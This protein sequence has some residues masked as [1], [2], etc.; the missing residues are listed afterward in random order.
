MKQKFSRSNKKES[1]RVSKDKKKAFSKPP[2]LNVFYISLAIN[3]V[4]IIGIL[5]L[6]NRLPPQLPLFYGLP[7][8]KEQ[9]TTKLGLTTAA[10]TALG[11]VLM[12]AILSAFLRNEFLRKTLILVGFAVSFL[13]L[14]TTAEIILLIGVF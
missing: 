1:K 4:A 9:L 10:F 8:G 2:F 5:L 6:G 7:E 3:T 11:I 13:S 14:I 12:N